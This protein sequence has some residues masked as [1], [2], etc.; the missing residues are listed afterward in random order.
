MHVRFATLTA[1][2]TLSVAVIVPAAVDALTI[3]EHDSARGGDRFQVRC[4][5]SD[6]SSWQLPAGATNVEVTRPAVGDTVRDGFGDK[7][8][9]TITAVEQRPEGGRTVVDVTATGSHSACEPVGG[10]PNPY[11]WE[12]NGV[13]FAAEFDLVR[14]VR[15]LFSDEQGGLNPRQRP[16]DIWATY[17]T[18]WERLKW[19]SWGDRTAIGKGKFVGRE[20]VVRNGDAD[21]APVVRDVRVKLSRVRICGSNRYYYTKLKTTFL[22]PTP[23]EIERQAQP[24]GAAGCLD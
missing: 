15:V 21:Y 19:Q 7:I 2:L 18:G 16:K 11:E 1:A 6:T 10:Q 5:Q 12:T 3:K 4:G 14:E 23:R 22:E 17:D 9:A 13:V 24:P 20:I 8:L